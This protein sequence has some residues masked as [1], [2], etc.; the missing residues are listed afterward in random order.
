MSSPIM[1]ISCTT[2][3]IRWVGNGFYDHN[4][5]PRN[6]NSLKAILVEL[7]NFSFLEMRRTRENITRNHLIIY[8][9]YSRFLD[10]PIK[11]IF[12]FFS[13][14][15]QWI[16][17]FVDQWKRIKN[18]EINPH[19]YSQMIFDKCVNTNQWENDTL[20]NSTGTTAYPHAKKMSLDP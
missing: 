2:L 20:L 15:D 16:H 5:G 11:I 1:N 17:V 8:H 7:G 12:S 9:S 4:F 18:P 19:I 14:N 10:F 6:V 13:K 3:E